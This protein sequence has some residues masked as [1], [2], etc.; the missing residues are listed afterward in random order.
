[1]VITA[2]VITAVVITDVVITASLQTEHAVVLRW[3]IG[4][5]ISEEIMLRTC[6]DKLVMNSLKEHPR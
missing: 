5:H 2:V 3:K 1:M 6:K 4:F